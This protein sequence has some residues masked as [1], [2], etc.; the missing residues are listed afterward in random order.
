[1]LEKLATRLREHHAAAIAI[2]QVLPEFHFEIRDLAAQGR[3]ANRQKSG[4][5]RE[6]AEFG[7]VAEILELLEIQWKA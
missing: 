1:M 2:E 3:L 7:N 4:G 6:A 5:M